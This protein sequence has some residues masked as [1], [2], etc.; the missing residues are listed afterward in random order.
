MNSL[1]EELKKPFSVN[2]INWRVGATNQDKTKGI[3]LAYL[4]SRAVMERLD[5]VCGVNWQCRYPFQGCCE[6]GIYIDSQWLWRANGAGETQVEAEKGQYSDAF[7]RAA[8]LWGIGRYLYDLPNAWLP[9]E[10]KGR[11]YGFSKQ[12]IKEL[13]ERLLAWQNNKFGG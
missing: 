7:K 8:V 4:D 1:F 3:A 12:T 6:I 13:N 2:F 9:L 11:S 5:S 10:A